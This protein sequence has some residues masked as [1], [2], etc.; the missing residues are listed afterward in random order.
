M[1]GRSTRRDIQTGDHNVTGSTLS[2]TTLEECQQAADA[3]GGVFFCSKDGLA[4][5]KN[6][7]WL[8][9]DT[10]STVVQGYVGYTEVPTE[11]RLP[12]L[13]DRQ[14]AG[15]W[16]GSINHAAFA[17]EGGT[18]QEAED[19][20]SQSY[21]GLRSQ[22]RTDLHNTTDG[23]VLAFAVR[24]VNAFEGSTIPDSTRSL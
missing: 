20:Q 3:E 5:F 23:E 14:R 8:T 11:S 2:D 24:V 9:T 4:I 16:P 17:R 22:K 19:V 7:D 12:M 10:R 21:Y 13:R 15:S 18:A 1:D 6:K